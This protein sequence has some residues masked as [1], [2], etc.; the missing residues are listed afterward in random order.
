MINIVTIL[1]IWN[2]VNRK[3]GQLA[4]SHNS[5]N[6]CSYHSQQTENTGLPR[7]EIL[8]S[9]REKLIRLK[10]HFQLIPGHTTVGSRNVIKAGRET[11]ILYRAQL[12]P[13]LHGLITFLRVLT[14]CFRLLLQELETKWLSDWASTGWQMA[15]NNVSRRDKHIKLQKYLPLKMNSTKSETGISELM[16]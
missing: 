2:L 7:V 11:C 12:P 1:S 8:K 13:A 4:D 15:N 16:E 10:S 14:L 9:S 3:P 6:F 5:H